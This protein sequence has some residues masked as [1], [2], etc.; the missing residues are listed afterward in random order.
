MAL[1]NTLIEK[2]LDKNSSSESLPRRK[3]ESKISTERRSALIAGTITSLAEFGI[4]GTTISTISTASNSSRGLIAHYFDSKEA[5]LSAALKRLHN[6]FSQS[7]YK[8]I[9]NPELNARQPLALFPQELFSKSVFTQRNRSVFLCLW[10]ETRFNKMVRR[11]NQDFDRGYVARMERLFYEAAVALHGEEKSLLKPAK[12]A[13][14]GFIGLSDGLWL[15]MSMH[16]KLIERKSAVATCTR[17]IDN[18]LAA[19]GSVL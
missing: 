16:D 3:K 2:S 4:A 15:G 6:D 11:A 19:M 17:Y 18:E 5:L 8:K 10:H 13:T 1:K 9:D 12:A 7:V 14:I